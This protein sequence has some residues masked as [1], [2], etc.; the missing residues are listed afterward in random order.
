MSKETPQIN[1]TECKS[2][3][4]AAHGHCAKTNT[5]AVTYKSGDTYHYPNFDAKQYEALQKAESVGSFVSK[6]IRGLKFEKQEKSK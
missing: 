3:N 6:N 2:S 4:I 5:L 1:F